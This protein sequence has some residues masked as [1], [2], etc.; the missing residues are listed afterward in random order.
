MPTISP[1]DFGRGRVKDLPRSLLSATGIKDESFGI[2]TQGV[3]L[4][5]A[6]EL[7]DALSGLKT[8]RPIIK[9]SLRFRAY[10]AGS[11]IG[12]SS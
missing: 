10:E 9:D 7:A 6:G 1:Y 12:S 4:D 8:V 2:S 11:Q 5:A 3:K